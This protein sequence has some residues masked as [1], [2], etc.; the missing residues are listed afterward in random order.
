MCEKIIKERWTKYLERKEIITDKQFGFRK[1]RSC[2]I[3]LLS[4]YT[5]DRYCTGERRMGRLCILGYEE[6]IR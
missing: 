6:G 5:S 3:N 1:G 2:V 4:F